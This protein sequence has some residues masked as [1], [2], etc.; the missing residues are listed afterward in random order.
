ML[1]DFFLNETPEEK[2]DDAL[3]YAFIK[4]T[5]SNSVESVYNDLLEEGIRE[6]KKI[7]ELEKK[8]GDVQQVED[9]R[10]TIQDA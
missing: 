3:L 8:I 10:K 9:I 4:M 5:L 6:A 1:K 2:V 7:Q